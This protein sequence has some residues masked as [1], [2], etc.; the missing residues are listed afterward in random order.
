MALSFNFISAR[1]AELKFVDNPDPAGAARLRA[2][3]LTQFGQ[4]DSTETAEATFAAKLCRPQAQPVTF[5]VTLH[6]DISIGFKPLTVF[7]GESGDQK[8][9]ELAFVLVGMAAAGLVAFKLA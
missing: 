3:T 9:R 2:W 6:T 4:M 7:S 5:V 1:G 8:D